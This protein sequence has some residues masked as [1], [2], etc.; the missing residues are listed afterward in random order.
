MNTNH[1]LM[2]LSLL[3]LALVIAPATARA[4]TEADVV[5]VEQRLIQLETELLPFEARCDAIIIELWKFDGVGGWFQGKKKDTLK[6]EY[7]QAQ[8][9]ID[10]KMGEIRTLQNQVQKMVFQVAQAYE[11]AG[12]F[13]KAI[14]FYLKISNQTDE[15]KFRIASCYKAMKNYE[16]AIQWLMRMGQSDAVSLHIVDCYRLDNR[17][18]DAFTWLF[19]I[20]EPF[21]NSE[22]ELNALQLVRTYD[23]P[24]KLADFPDFNQRVSDVYINKAFCN[25]SSNFAQAR[26]DYREAI[27]LITNG[28]DERTTSFG[29]MT[30][31]QGKYQAACEVLEQQ[32]TAAEQYYADML[33]NAQRN[34]DEAQDRLRRAEYD[35]DQRYRYELQRSWDEL[36]RAQRELQQAQSAASP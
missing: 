28:Q 27:K 34:I 17:W 7:A 23:Y 26:D 19:K 33:R 4:V 22:S 32:K 16:S 15:V 35:A 3:A 12:N 25:Y 24:G 21:S 30:R 29:M 13:E 31:Y 10:G 6:K 9:S 5:A 1:R 18:R 11:Q 8:A 20:L 2:L 36:Q 14:D